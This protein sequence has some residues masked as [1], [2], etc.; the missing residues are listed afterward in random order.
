MSNGP[1][2]LT[3]CKRPSGVTIV[4]CPPPRKAAP[5]V[6]PLGETNFLGSGTNTERSS[7]K[8]KKLGK[9]NMLKSLSQS[10]HNHR[11]TSRIQRRCARRRRSLPALSMAAW[12]HM[13]ARRARWPR[14][15]AAAWQLA[16]LCVPS[17][18][19]RRPPCITHA[20]V[21]LFSTDRR[22]AVLRHVFGCVCVP[23]LCRRWFMG[24]LN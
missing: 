21:L 18:R 13:F 8:I 19:T 12:A 5:G 3:P 4:K 11:E 14:I 9:T 2:D 7:P 22:C 6:G 10:T 20:R 23:S 24:I 17:A 16:L 1:P 15:S